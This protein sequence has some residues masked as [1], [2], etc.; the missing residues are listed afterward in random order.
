MNTLFRIIV[1]LV[2]TAL[3][4]LS[5][6]AMAADSYLTYGTFKALTALCP[7][8]QSPL[9]AG[10]SEAG[11]GLWSQG[12]MRI[13]AKTH[14]FEG[15]FN[16]SG[17]SESAIVITDGSKNYVVIA[18]GNDKH[19]QR[20]GFVPIGKQTIKEWNGRALCIDEQSFVAWGGAKYRLERGALA[21]Y[22]NG[23]SAAQFNGVMIKLTYIGPQD[24][25][26]PGLLI[27]SFYRWP[28]LSE[29]K[30]HRSPGVFYGNDERP[31]MWHLTVSPEELQEFAV[32]INR[33]SFLPIAEDR[34]GTKGASHS[35]SILDT[36]SSKRPNYFEVFLVGQETSVLIDAFA[37]QLEKR[38]ADAGKMLR[39]YAKMFGG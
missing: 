8:V 16:H 24:E 9:L 1:V 25:P 15:D 33:A 28:D 19:W 6:T 3:I 10:L 27:S 5:G 17:K 34:K 18:E 11:Q 21:V 12:Q 20:T 4:A 38:N 23:Y 36:S 22:C 26:Y 14:V 32:T 30:S 35:L 2:V 31:V 29:F 13:P 37:A 39:E 7:E